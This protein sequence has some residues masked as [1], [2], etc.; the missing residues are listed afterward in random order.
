MDRVDIAIVGAGP[1]GAALAA[2]LATAGRRV[3]VFEARGG[4][5][6]D[7]RTLAL[8]QA[9]RELLEEVGGWPVNGVTPIDAIHVSQKGG[10]GRTL[11]TAAEQGLPALGY[12]VAYA[13]LEE[14]LA[15]R[16][17]SLGVQVLVGHALRSDRARRQRGKAAARGRGDRWRSR[18]WSLPTAAS[19]R[20]A[21]RGS[22]TRKRTM[23][24][25]P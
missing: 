5:S 17:A 24:R 25:W 16:I 1:V 2:L 21:S 6:A 3:R 20:G 11:I 7:A 14:L 13:A 18:C 8:S 12:T 22:P 23:A 15:S 10:P 9:S 19:T 4:P